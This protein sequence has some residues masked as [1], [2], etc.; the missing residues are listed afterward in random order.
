MFSLSPP[1]NLLLSIVF[2]GRFKGG[3]AA[4]AVEKGGETV[5]TEGR[6]KRF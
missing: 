6:K 5:V 1:L 3:R 2:V 4:V